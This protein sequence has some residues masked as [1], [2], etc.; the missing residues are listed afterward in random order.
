MNKPKRKYVHPFDL[1]MNP[2]GVFVS[3]S[4]EPTPLRFKFAPE[5]RAAIEEH[6]GNHEAERGAMLGGNRERAEVTAVYLDLT[7]R[8][9]G[10]EYSPDVD[11]LNRVLKDWEADGIEFLGF[12]H[13]HPRGVRHPSGA[14]EEYAG[15]IL[16][17]MS[18]LKS[19]LMPIVM[20][21][22]N[23][24][25]YELLGYVATRSNNR[26]T[27]SAAAIETSPELDDQSRVGGVSPP[28]KPILA[29]NDVR[30]TTASAG[31]NCPGASLQALQERAVSAYDLERLASTRVVVM[32]V[33][34]ARGLVE[35]LA[36]CFVGEFVLID[37][38]ESSASNVAT[39][40]AFLDDIGVPKV[41]ALAERIR[42]INPYARISTLKCRAQ[43]LAESKWRELLTPGAGA[44][45]VTLLIMTDNFETQAF[46]NRLALHFAVPS[47]AAGMYDQGG[48]C[49]V[50][51]THPEVTPACHRCATSSRYAAYLQSGYRNGTTSA[52]T[53]F[54]AIDMFNGLIGYVALAVM[55]HGS[56]H[57]RWGPLLQ[58]IGPRNLVLCKLSPDFELQPVDRALSGADSERMLA[59]N[60]AWCPQPG[61]HP[62]NHPNWEQCPDCGGH[63]D[64]RP[65]AGSFVADLYTM[66]LR[67]P[68]ALRE[69]TPR[70]EPA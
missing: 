67:V 44:R 6:I 24:G 33:G 12:V 34:G 48:G 61:D 9:A 16:Q 23:A 17:A 59:V 37:H 47:V 64:L 2:W 7:A 19:M 45:Y 32:G 29:P 14:D 70:F 55:H 11:T 22:P 50:T 5:V 65:L 60:T 68:D 54:P 38:D 20:T 49:E 15:R 51:F 41:A 63:G 57:K 4:E 39:Q 10:A 40:A 3:Q 26:V 36:R 13:S 18:G 46:G 53:P 25:E 66:R 52:G 27:V 1:A 28:K 42:A 35:S 31:H 58:R 21:K 43:D 62:K 69:P 8:T 30:T 56:D